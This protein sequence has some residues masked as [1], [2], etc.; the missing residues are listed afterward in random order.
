MAFPDTNL[1]M[2]DAMA[3]RDAEW[4]SRTHNGANCCG[5]DLSECGYCTFNGSMRCVY[6]T[7][8]RKLVLG[9]V[10]GFSDSIFPT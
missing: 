10:Y 4:R 2:L 8:A 6:W 1:E 9:D 7:M 5:E 3:K